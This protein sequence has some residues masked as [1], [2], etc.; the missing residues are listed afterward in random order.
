MTSL[1][2][3]PLI[4]PHI[5]NLM[6]KLCCVILLQTTLPLVLHHKF[7]S[8]WSM[9]VTKKHFWQTP[10]RKFNGSLST[11]CLHVHL[12][13]TSSSRIY[14]TYL[15]PY[16]QRKQSQRMKMTNLGLQASI[17][18]KSRSSKGHSTEVIIQ[19]RRLRNVINHLACKLRAACYGSKVNTV[20]SGNSKK[21][22]PEVNTLMGR[23]Q[24]NNALANIANKLTGGDILFHTNEINR[25]F[26]SISSELPKLTPTH[27]HQ[28]SPQP[29]KYIYSIGC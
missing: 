16:C 8:H 15:I 11:R 19:N 22:W 21:W 20:T 6:T 27:E 29:R 1:Y 17:K 5:G 7:A 25:T 26:Q 24:P 23:K 28:E 12:S 10:Y 4:C 13:S 2:V 9:V 14:K 18:V 3:T